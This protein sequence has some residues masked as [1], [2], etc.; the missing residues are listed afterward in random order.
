MKLL[1]NFKQL[2]PKEFFN[3]WKQGINKVT[4]LDQT[5]I[6]IYGYIFVLVGILIGCYSTIVTKTWWLLVIL[7]GSFVLTAMG[8]IGTLQKY[9]ALADM[10]NL[11]KQMQEVK[12]V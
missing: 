10:N 9:F 1:Q 2:G 8:F 7:V 11:I 12:N 3:R 6:S 4:P 5:F